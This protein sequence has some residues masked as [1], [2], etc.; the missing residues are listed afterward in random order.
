MLD[1]AKN[2]LI[3]V[4][5]GPGVFSIR[6]TLVQRSSSSL[7]RRLQIEVIAVHCDVTNVKIITPVKSK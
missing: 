2:L 3:S 7:N 5:D 1:D 6:T 4:V